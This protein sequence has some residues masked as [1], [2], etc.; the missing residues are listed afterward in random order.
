M[1]P[2]QFYKR[3]LPC[4]LEIIKDIDLSTLE[5][6]LIDG[7]IYTDNEKTYGLGAHLYNKLHEKVP[8][9]GVAKTPFHT[10]SETVEEVYRGESK[11]PLLVSAIGIDQMISV[12]YIKSMKGKYRMPTILKE[13][14]T[15]TKVD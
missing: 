13:L 4:I 9:I 8:I 2:G 12:N 7:H 11:N 10:N 14:D 5:A 15:I 6:I 1:I 3:E